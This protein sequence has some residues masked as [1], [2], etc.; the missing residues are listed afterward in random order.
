M[1]DRSDLEKAD[2]PT[3]QAVSVL[4]AGTHTTLRCEQWV[5]KALGEVFAFFADAHNLEQI[6]PP[7]LRFSVRSMTTLA[8]RQGTEITYRLRLHRLP[9]PWTSRIEVWEPPY[10]FTDVQVRGPFRLWRHQHDFA[11]ENNGTSIRDTVHYRPP[12]AWLQRT[13]LL[14]WVDNDLRRI[15]TC[16]QQIIECLFGG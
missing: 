15:F 9:I 12:C 8:V 11:P 6:T 5:P 14:W 2:H 16:R 3:M 4:P 7:F 13:P 1:A 10:R